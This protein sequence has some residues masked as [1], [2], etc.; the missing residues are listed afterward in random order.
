ITDAAG[1]Q[2]DLFVANPFAPL[3]NLIAEGKLRVLAVTGPR[4]LQA[5]PNVATLAELGYPEANLTSLF[6]FYAPASMP[7]DHVQRVNAAV[8]QILA[9]N[10]VQ[11]QLRKLD[12]VVSTGTPQQFAAVIDREFASN[13]K[14]VKEANIKA[15]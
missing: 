2:F 3:N 9:D 14:I 13:A 8:N 11:E 10:G 4:R 1:G 7:A 12:N 15:E 5:M 6:G